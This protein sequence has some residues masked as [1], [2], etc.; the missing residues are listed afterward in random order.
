MILALALF[1]IPESR[2]MVPKRGLAEQ[3][4]AIR[5]KMHELEK[6]VAAS[7][8][9][10]SNAQTHL[11]R[12][13][14]LIRLQKQEKEIS[15]RRVKNL[16]DTIE[17]LEG[18]RARLKEKIE[19][20]K[21][22]IRLTLRDIRRSQ[23]E[24]PKG[25]N[26]LEKE[27]LEAP[28]RKVLSRLVER[29]L[30][31]VEVVKADV[32]DADLLE[33]RIFEERSQLIALIHDI[34]EKEGVLEF[35]EK[36]QSDLMAK[37]GQ[38]KLEQLDSYQKL[39]IAEAD[40][41]KLL[42]D[43]N[44]RMELRESLAR[45]KSAAAPITQLTALQG[46]LD[47][48][49]MGRIVGFFGKSLDQKSKLQVFKKGIEIEVAPG[50][51]VSAI[52]AGKVAFSGE[53]PNLGKIAIIDHGNHFY[54]ISGKLEKLSCKAGDSIQKGA[55]IGTTARNGDPLYFELRTNNIPIN[56]V[57]WLKKTERS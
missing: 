33:K 13:R 21:K 22:A 41:E 46:K 9:S 14:A 52:L 40:V 35:N 49:V 31:E 7:G 5:D 10:H 16:E 39:K 51:E 3:L 37:K 24:V 36:I 4:G 47:Y 11:K 57:Q 26:L 12:V 18:R 20:S 2:A 32:A 54:S 53:V 29:S 56:P 1:L 15:L 17:T 27:K 34:D 28:R 30:R 6:S 42:K 44:V 8:K 45:E 19:E 55:S 23:S 25:W 43:F 50:Q 48:P 38:E